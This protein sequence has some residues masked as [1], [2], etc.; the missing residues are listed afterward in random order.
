MKYNKPALPISQQ[1]RHL[2]YRGMGFKEPELAAHHLK[3]LNYYRLS[4]YWQRYLQ[5]DDKVNFRRGTTFEKVLA[6]YVFDRDLKILVLDAVETVEVSVRTHWAHA[7][8]LRYGAHAHLDGTL[9][10]S[11]HQYW[12]HPEAVAHLVQTIRQSRERFI[13]H[14]KGKYDEPLPPIWAVVEVMSLGQISRW[15]TNLRHAP[16]R[17]DIA[18]DYAISE[19]LLSSFLHH[20]SVVRNL[21]AHHARFW[22]RKLSLKTGLP[23]KNPAPLVQSLRHSQ[24][25]CTYNTLTL[26]AW[27][28]SRIDPSS[29]WATRVKTRILGHPPACTEMGFPPSFKDSPVWRT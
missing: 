16:D 15:F 2:Q 17:R 18:S 3:N 12:S 4:G 28:V 24:G 21:C 7:L 5:P 19:Q 29:N 14:L 26:L 20:I 22:D 11:E 23:R 6:D 8:G 10:K 13:L 9:F 25:N 27:M 1:I